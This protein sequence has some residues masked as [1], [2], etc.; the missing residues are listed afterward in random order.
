MKLKNM[1]QKDKKMLFLHVIGLIEKI[2]L[3]R[4]N[5]HS[6]ISKNYRNIELRSIRYLFCEFRDKFED[7]SSDLIFIQ[8]YDVGLQM[9]PVC[10][11]NNS[12]NFDVKAALD[13]LNNLYRKI[14]YQSQWSPFYLSV[15]KCL[16]GNL[17]FNFVSE[18]PKK[19]KC[20]NIFIIW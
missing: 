15:D 13:L 5:L 16:G 4:E 7:N 19:K 18:N 8:K 12:A 6:I 14:E 10:T 3:L 9:I 20:I 2:C 11:I 1:P 17:S